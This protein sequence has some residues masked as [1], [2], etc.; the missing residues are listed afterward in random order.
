[1]ALGVDSLHPPVDKGAVELGVGV[2]I[3][4]LRSANLHQG[5]PKCGTL[6]K[7]SREEKNRKMTF[8]GHRTFTKIYR[9]RK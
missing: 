7:L 3:G 6:L 1:M 4:E 8:R 2:S 5:T 9:R